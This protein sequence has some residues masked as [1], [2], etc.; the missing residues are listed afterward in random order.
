MSR[1]LGDVLAHRVGVSSEPDVST[2]SLSLTDRFII[3]GSDGVWD[4][5]SSEE[6]VMLVASCNSPEEATR[7]LVDTAHARWMVEEEGVVDDIT[8][9]VVALSANA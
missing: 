1:S 5:I 6:A 9:I 2:Y 8:C 7:L 3:I 4:F